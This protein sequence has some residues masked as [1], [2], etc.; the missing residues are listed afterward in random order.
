MDATETT[1]AE[2]PTP[3]PASTDGHRSLDERIAIGKAQAKEL[4]LEQI[5]DPP[6]REGRPDIVEVLKSESEGRITNLLPLRHARMAAGPFATLRGTAGIMAADLASRPSTNLIVQ[7]C[8]D[9]HLSNFG[10]YASPERSLVFDVNDFDETHPG[11]FEWDVLRLATSF[12]SCVHAQGDSEKAA[13]LARKVATVYQAAM[14]DLAGR[15]T[16]D[17]LYER[18]TAEDIEALAEESESAAAVKEAEAALEKARRR[19]QERAISRLTEVVD[20]ARRFKTTP[21]VLIRCEDD[22]IREGYQKEFAAY[23]DTLP[24][25]CQAIARRYAV[26]DFAMKVVG[27]GSVGNFTWV[28]LLEGRDA[29]DQIVLQMKQATPSVLA[30][31]VKHTGEFSRFDHEGERIVRGQKMMQAVSDLF[32]GWLDG[33]PGT[34]RQYYARQL[35]DMKGGFNV[36]NAKFATIET[37]ANL[38]AHTLARAHARSG[39]AVAIAAYLESDDKFADAVEVFAVA[40]SHF[41]DGDHKRLVD[42][43]AGGEIEAKDAE[44]A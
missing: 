23:I 33:V 44:D 9:A 21:P 1:V 31:Y 25:E 4:P 29:D 22:A 7:L 30:P 27:I 28:A 41:V 38:C 36:E 39:D 14:T 19:T 13:S 32:L 10:I 35:H 2:S 5:G 11:P 26:V 12:V 18:M 6:A 40:E 17:V 20:G 43:I 3:E 34:N 24:A 8:G 15:S 42:A 37:Y 16:L